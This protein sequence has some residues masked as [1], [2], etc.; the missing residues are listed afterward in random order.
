[1]KSRTTVIAIVAMLAGL[2]LGAAFAPAARAQAERSLLE[3]AQVVQ[4]FG[5]G[6]YIGVSIRDLDEEAVTKAGLGNQSGVLIEDVQDDSP[7]EDA[8]FREGDVVV[9]FDGER[10]RS[11]RQ[12]TRL[13]QETPAGREVQTVVVRDGSRTTLTVTPRAS[14]RQGWSFR[15]DDEGPRVIIPPAPAPPAPPAPPVPPRAPRFD[16]LPEFDRFFS[17]SGRL[18]ITVDSLSDQLAEYFGV[19][20]GVL[21]TA[22]TSGSSADKAGVKAGDV[23]VSING[24]AVDSTTDLARR[25]L[26]LE[27][28]DEFTLEVVRKGER[29]TLKG[30]VEASRR[31]RGRVRTVI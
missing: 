1:M 20:D 10:V 3:A 16:I 9:E 17:S 27:E 22:V 13:V 25:A 26:R 6:S 12:F 24:E 29:Q 4:W 19:E 8:G 18:G 15:F 5:S 30:L 14:G 23:I 28:G 21:V 31:S 11:T 7:A 2:G